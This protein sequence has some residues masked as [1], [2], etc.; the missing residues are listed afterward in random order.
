M[1][2]VSGVEGVLGG[3]TFWGRTTMSPSLSEMA[4]PYLLTDEGWGE[5]MSDRCE[6]EPHFQAFQIKA[7]TNN[8]LSNNACGRVI[9]R[10]ADPWVEEPRKM[11]NDVEAKLNHVSDRRRKGIVQLF[12]LEFG[13]I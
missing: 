9:F 2:D 1:L 7:D 10:I 6:H 4:N 12:Q 11:T 8:T 13:T 3:L 5:L